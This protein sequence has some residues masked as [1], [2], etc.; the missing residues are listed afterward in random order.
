MSQELELLDPTPNIFA[1]F[2]VGFNVR[3]D[4]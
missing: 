2:D 4:G 1:L 3:G